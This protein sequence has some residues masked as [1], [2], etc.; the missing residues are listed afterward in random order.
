V[1][2]VNLLLTTITFGLYSPWAK[3]RNNQYL[4]GNAYLG[5]HSFEYTA[6]AFR[7]LIGRLIVVGGYI[8]FFVCANIGYLE[9]AALIAAVFIALIPFFIRQSVAFKRRYTRF[10]GVSFKHTASALSY[11][12]ATLPMLILF[13][14]YAAF[15]LGAFW[16][17]SIFG[18]LLLMSRYFL[19]DVVWV[20]LPHIIYVVVVA[21]LI[22]YVFASIKR[23]IIGKTSY[24]HTPIEYNLKT[25]SVYLVFFKYS[26][27]VLAFIVIPLIVIHLFYGN[28]YL[29]R[30]PTPLITLYFTS[31]FVFY[32]AKGAFDAWIGRVDFN[33]CSI[34]GFKTFCE[35][36]VG[37]LVKIYIVNFFCSIFL[38]RS[39]IP[40]GK[41]SRS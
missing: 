9:V 27:I 12:K 18:N 20:Y 31:M 38:L 24:G 13:A 40:L 34:G 39:I 32:A 4:Y 14:I 41:G 8:M 23:L 26:L 2:I 36:R 30:V 29:E 15:I 1:W 22:P 28:D 35:Y 5:D 33:N 19:D 16:S 17:M 10:R 3:V 7:I 6:N 11:Y 25:S 21:L 37:E